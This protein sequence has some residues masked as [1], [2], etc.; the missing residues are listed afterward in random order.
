MCAGLPAAYQRQEV[1]RA[2]VRCTDAV[3]EGIPTRSVELQ[4]LDKTGRVVGQARFYWNPP[5]PR[6]RQVRP[7]D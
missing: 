3:D 7:P 6:K 1:V 4:T 2:R 5:A